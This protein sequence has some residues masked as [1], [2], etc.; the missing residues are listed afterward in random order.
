MDDIVYGAMVHVSL[1]GG[2]GGPDMSETSAAQLRREAAKAR[3]LAEAAFGETERKRLNE[4]AVTLDSE[5]AAIE[6][7]VVRTRR[8]IRSQSARP[9]P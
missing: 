8:R 2:G 1:N 4:V 5:A 9:L 3:K 6:A 7:A